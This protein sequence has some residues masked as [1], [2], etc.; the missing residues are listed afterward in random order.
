MILLTKSY[1]ITQNGLKLITPHEYDSLKG[2]DIGD[3]WDDDDS[4][5][6]GTLN[7]Y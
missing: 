4:Q 2:P 1:A 6:S 3:F 5:E 7:P